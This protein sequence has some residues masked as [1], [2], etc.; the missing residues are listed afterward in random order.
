MVIYSQERNQVINSNI[1]QRF[2]V[3]KDVT[4]GGDYIIGCDLLSMP[5][6]GIR[7]GIYADE[8]EALKELDG[9]F[10]AMAHDEKEHYIG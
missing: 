4:A 6:N 8:D 5:E 7:L 10:Y 2:W 9:I 3:T 1:T